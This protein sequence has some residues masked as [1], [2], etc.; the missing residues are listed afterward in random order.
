[1]RVARDLRGLVIGCAVFAEAGCHEHPR[2]REPVA[3]SSSARPQAVEVKAMS[4]APC[5]RDEW[6]RLFDPWAK[7]RNLERVRECVNSG[8]LDAQDEWGVTALGSALAQKWLEGAAVVLAAHANTEL[9]YYRTGTTVLYEAV[10]ERN[11]PGIRLLLEGGANPDAANYWGVTA[12]DMANH[13]GVEGM[14]S[15]TPV[16][17]TDPEPLI[18]N[19]EHLA[20][21]YYPN[22]EIPTRDERE[23]LQPGQAVDLY[24]YGKN[25]KATTKVRIQERKEAEA[26]VAYVGILDPADQETNLK[27][28]T[29]VVSFGPE[30]V[31]TVYTQQPR[32]SP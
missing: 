3:S 22:F 12:R 15:G 18:Q 17:R 5:S 25:K 4:V 21:H 27:A 11:E 32:L 7:V 13:A 10:L 14:F 29:T 9:R 1:M 30:H 16:N 8:W 31:A 6:F 20:D 23:S 2:P 24:V 26:S 28:G 19:A